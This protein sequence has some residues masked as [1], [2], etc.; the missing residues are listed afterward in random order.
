M[1]LTDSGMVCDVCG[2]P[3][4][5]EPRFESFKVAGIDA[6]LHAHPDCRPLVEKA[7]KDWRNLPRGPLRA[8]FEESHARPCPFCGS[9]ITSWGDGFYR[10][11]SR[12]C[13]ASRIAATIY[14]WNGQCS[15]CP[16]ASALARIVH[17]NDT[18]WS[19]CEE[20]E[21]PE[22]NHPLNK[23][24]AAMHHGRKALQDFGLL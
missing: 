1:S 7:G 20:F 11:S 9:P 12:E 24:G 6:E 14:Q 8:V 18:G 13:P 16:I 23:M 19:T 17:V 2:L 22:G 10:C 5:V 15:M 4:T 3:F 21:H